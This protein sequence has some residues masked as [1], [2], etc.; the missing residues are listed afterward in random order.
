MR[1]IGRAHSEIETSGNSDRLRDWKSVYEPRNVSIIPR[2]FLFTEN[3]ERFYIDFS[4]RGSNRTFKNTCSKTH[5]YS[6]FDR[7]KFDTKLHLFYS[8]FDTFKFE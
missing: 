2:G 5:F 8:I 3:K 4:Q 1:Q 6:T 7:F